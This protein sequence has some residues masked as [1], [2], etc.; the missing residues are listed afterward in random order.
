MAVETSSGEGTSPRYLVHG[1]LQSVR[2]IV[3][4]NTESRFTDTNTMRR[5]TN[6]PSWQTW[7]DRKNRGQHP[8]RITRALVKGL[9]YGPEDEEQ[10]T[11]VGADEGDPHLE[12]TYP[13]LGG[14]QESSTPE[15]SLRDLQ[16]W[17]SV[18]CLEERANNDWVPEYRFKRLTC[19]SALPRS[20][21]Q[22]KSPD[23]YPGLDT[24]V[25]W[26]IAKG[27]GPRPSNTKDLMEVFRV[28]QIDDDAHSGVSSFVEETYSQLSEILDGWNRHVSEENDGAKARDE[29]LAA[30]EERRHLVGKV[31]KKLKRR[32]ELDQQSA[33][34]LKALH[35]FRPEIATFKNQTPYDILVVIAA[36]VRISK[37]DIDQGIIDSIYRALLTEIRLH[38]D[39]RLDAETA[40]I[41]A[42]ILAAARV[43]NQEEVNRLTTEKHSANLKMFGI[44]QETLIGDIRRARRNLW[45]KALRD[46][47]SLTV[48]Q[49]A[50]KWA[51]FNQTSLPAEL[52]KE[53]CSKAD[54]NLNDRSVSRVLKLGARNV[55][56]P[57]EQE[58]VKKRLQNPETANMMMGIR[59]ENREVGVT[60]KFMLGRLTSLE[61]SLQEAYEATENSFREHDALLD[62]VGDW[63]E[64]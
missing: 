36:N 64:G 44:A 16:D 37:P 7:K 19:S 6:P 15:A 43:S 10:E 26:R 18:L 33:R 3:V 13:S 41:R 12:T 25:P 17:L 8:P 59:E 27:L 47:Q 61:S 52:L 34:L 35:A 62:T 56:D 30:L 60:T 4:T 48:L 24:E 28:P 5:S 55:E 40:R 20:S 49:A 21:G 38:L 46:L 1:F 54:V 57:V 51:I 31:W 50:Q 22:E 23:T 14:G 9:L 45:R 58:R 63:P 32:K 2:H 53:K 39:K 42:G 29:L 11:Y